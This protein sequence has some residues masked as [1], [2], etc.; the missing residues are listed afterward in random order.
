MSFLHPQLLWLLL[1]PAA[2]VGLSVSSVFGASRAPAAYPKI[3]H[4]R[5]GP[6]SFVIGRSS[7]A[8][9][10]P[11]VAALALALLITALA[12]PQGGEIATPSV[13]RARDVLVAVDVSRSMLADDVAP[14]RLERDRKS[15]V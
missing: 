1:A 10:R 4:A 15:V 8:S 14:S 3:P 5:L 9:P 7:F 13:V 12:R 6:A 11:V 2:L